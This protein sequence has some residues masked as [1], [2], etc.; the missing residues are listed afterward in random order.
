[1]N[2]EPEVHLEDLVDEVAELLKAQ[3]VSDRERKGD[4]W[5]HLP[6]EGQAHR[7]ADR[8]DHYF[9]QHAWYGAPMPW[10]KVM[11]LAMI[12]LVREIHPETLIEK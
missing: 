3:F 12:G 4:E 11:G 2:T 9:G 8:F 6:K 10:L 1:M 5:R 7:I